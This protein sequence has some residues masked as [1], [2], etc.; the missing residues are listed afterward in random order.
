MKH[1]VT[2]H[3][4]GH[5]Q[6]MH[7]STPPAG[8][9]YA[10][11]QGE[12]GLIPQEI[13]PDGPLCTETVIPCPHGLGKTRRCGVEPWA[14]LHIDIAFEGG[15]DFF[16]R[17]AAWRPLLEIVKLDPCAVYIPF[18]CGARTIA[19]IYIGIASVGLR[20]CKGCF[21]LNMSPRNRPDKARLCLP[22]HS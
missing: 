9:C 13:S 14:S 19:R 21:Q 17:K 15:G 20:R 11:G 5:R 12:N 2:C 18:P 3:T 1:V 7:L 8:R 4:W 22:L 10:M 16:S 6:H